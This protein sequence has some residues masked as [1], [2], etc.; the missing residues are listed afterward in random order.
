ML[1][2][3]I[4]PLAVIAVTSGFT[5]AQ[6]RRLDPQEQTRLIDSTEL[7]T[8]YANSDAARKRFPAL[9]FCLANEWVLSY[10]PFQVGPSPKSVTSDGPRPAP[11]SQQSIYNHGLDN[12]LI[13]RNAKTLLLVVDD[14]SWTG[15]IS[16]AEK[17]GY[18]RQLSHGEMVVSHLRYILED[19]KLY[20]TPSMI[21]SDLVYKSRRTGSYIYIRRVEIKKREEQVLNSIVNILTAEEVAKTIDRSIKPNDKFNNV[22][23]NMSFV[24]IPCRVLVDFKLYQDSDKGKKER[25]N[26]SFASY[27]NHVYSKRM[28][29]S[30]YEQ[31]RQA[32]A[33][34]PDNNPLSQSIK[35]LIEGRKM[36]GL[37]VASSGNFGLDIQFAPAS[38]PE[39]IGVGAVADRAVTDNDFTHVNDGKPGHTKLNW[40]NAADVYAPREWMAFNTETLDSYCAATPTNSCPM[41]PGDRSKWPFLAYSGTSFSAPSVS[42]YLAMRLQGSSSC[43]VNVGNHFRYFDLSS[44]GSYKPLEKMNG[45]NQP[46]PVFKW[47]PGILNGQC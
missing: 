3:P 10:Q 23:L 47:K 2:F 17:N 5:Q 8:G 18:Q 14:Y 22:I 25:E 12:A 43:Y 1:R 40:S 34:M 15:D 45:M 42:A 28:N 37:A 21:G 31:K 38:R 32:I 13:A 27:L 30:N 19:T 41:K 44:G 20:D 9:Q 33:E 16:G 46:R 35:R 29:S 6:F 39:V 7:L 24:T 36:K 4:L 11:P 26:P